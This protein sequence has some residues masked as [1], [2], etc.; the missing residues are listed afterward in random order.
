[1]TWIIVNFNNLPSTLVICYI[2]PRIIA[3]V[4]YVGQ[5]NLM[6]PRGMGNWAMLWIHVNGTWQEATTAPKSGPKTVDKRWLII[7]LAAILLSVLLCDNERRTCCFPPLRLSFGNHR[8]ELSPGTVF[9]CAEKCPGGQ[10]GTE[11]Q[12]VMVGTGWPT[13]SKALANDGTLYSEIKSEEGKWK[14]ECKVF[15]LQ[16][17]FSGVALFFGH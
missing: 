12:R 14:S 4:S 16:Q 13:S 10:W 8:E 2:T 7:S 6:L 5:F 11:Q 15:I 1:M 9:N 17:G 3:L